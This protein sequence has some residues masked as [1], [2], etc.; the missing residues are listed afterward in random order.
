MSGGLIPQ[1]RVQRRTVEKMVDE[2]VPRKVV[3]VMSG[4]E[5]CGRTSEQIVDVQVPE[6]M[7]DAVGK[8]IRLVPQ[9][10]IQ[11]STVEFIDV[12]VSRATA[13]IN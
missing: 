5:V 10:K 13:E 8:M 12:P 2:L 6:I 9:E 3:G 1:E 7:E 4:G 11:G